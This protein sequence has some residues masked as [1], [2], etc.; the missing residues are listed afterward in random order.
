MPDNANISSLLNQAMSDEPSSSAAAYTPD[1]T[2]DEPR[3]ETAPTA[4]QLA[5]RKKKNRQLFNRK[6]GDLLDDVLRNLDILVYAELSAIYYMEC[7]VNAD[8]HR[9]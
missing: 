6:R 2:H 8:G 9:T 1:V 3:T 4:V 5:E 7:V